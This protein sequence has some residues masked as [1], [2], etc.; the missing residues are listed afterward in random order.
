MADRLMNDDDDDDDAGD[1]LLSKSSDVFPW[2]VSINFSIV[3][4]QDLPGFFLFSSY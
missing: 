2:G 3:T 1:T 4:V